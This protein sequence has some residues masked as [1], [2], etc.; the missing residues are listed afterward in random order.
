MAKRDVIKVLERQRDRALDELGFEYV[1]TGYYGA[2][3][4]QKNFEW[5]RKDR[6]EHDKAADKAQKLVPEGFRPALERALLKAQNVVLRRFKLVTMGKDNKALFDLS[7]YLANKVA[8]KDDPETTF[9]AI[10]D[11]EQKADR[12]FLKN[13]RDEILFE[14]QKVEEQ[15]LLD[16]VNDATKAMATEFAGRLERILELT[17]I[18]TDDS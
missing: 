16:G 14:F 18:A 13:V 10:V 2:Y 11:E 1:Q 3:S 5:I 12:E 15:I 7:T 4:R 17:S 9:K 6:Y 8:P